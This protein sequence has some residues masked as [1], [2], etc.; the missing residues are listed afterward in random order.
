VF[1]EDAPLADA[2]QPLLA[3]GAAIPPANLPAAAAVQTVP[4]VTGGSGASAQP[5]AAAPRTF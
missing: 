5:M 2:A 1:I 4:V 3:R